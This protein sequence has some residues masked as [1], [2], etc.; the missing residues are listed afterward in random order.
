M[1]AKKQRTMNEEKKQRLILRLKTAKDEALLRR[2]RDKQAKQLARKVSRE[3]QKKRRARRTDSDQNNNVQCQ[4]NLNE[5]PPKKQLRQTDLTLNPTN[6]VQRNN[7]PP[8][9]TPRSVNLITN[10]PKKKQRRRTDSTPNPTNQV[11]PNNEPPNS[12]SVPG[13]S[14]QQVHRK[15]KP[16]RKEQ[17]KEYSRRYRAKKKEN[18][19]SA[20]E[21]K[22]KEHARYL[23]RKESKQ[24]K[25]IADMTAREQRKMR[26]RWRENTRSSRTRRQIAHDADSYM[27]GNSPPETPANPSGAENAAEHSQSGGTEKKKQGS[28]KA[29]RRKV[30]RDRA[31]AYV[32]LKKA[33]RELLDANRRADKWK[34]RCIRMEGTFRPKGV[35]P[36]PRTKVRKMLKGCRVPHDVRKR[37]EY[38]E[39]LQKQLKH[40]AEQAATESEKQLFARS[41]SGCI[42][43]KYKMKSNSKHLLSRR[44][45]DL[46]CQSRIHIR[47]IR[48]SA[49]SAMQVKQ[50]CSFL[51]DDAN[52]RICAGKREY[53]LR[54]GQKKQK[55]YLCDTMLNLHSKFC[56]QHI[57]VMSYATFCRLRPFWIVEPKAKDRE[58]CGCVKHDNM[59]FLVSKLNMLG[60]IGPKTPYEL[61]EA[62]ACYTGSKSCMYGECLDCRD[63]AI[64]R[65]QPSE[66]NNN[67]FFYRWSTRN[68]NRVRAKDGVPIVVK[69]TAKEK[70]ACTTD[71]MFSFLA[72]EMPS[73]KEHEYRMN[74]Q[75]NI[76]TE[77][78]ASLLPNEGILIID[79]SEN[80]S[81]KYSSETQSVHFGASRQQ[82]TL[83]TGVLY[84]MSGDRALGCKSFCSVSESLRHDPSAIWAHLKPIFNMLA[85]SFPQI[86]TL[87]IWSDGPTTQYRNRRNFGIFSVLHHFGNFK[88][89]TWNYTE[90]GHG[91]AAADGIG[92]WL[93]RQADGLVAHGT[94]IT[95]AS[96]L[97][98]ALQADR[99]ETELYM[100]T[101]DDIKAIDFQFDTSAVKCIK[102]TMKLHQLAWTNTRPKSL[103]MRYLSCLE[104]PAEA[105]C[106][107]YSVGG[108]LLMNV[109]VTDKSMPQP[110][111][112]TR[113][114]KTPRNMSAQPVAC[115]RAPKTPRN[116]SAQPVTRTRA[117]KKPRDMSAELV[118]PAANPETS[119]QQP[120]DMS[121][122]LVTPA[123]HPETSQQ[124]A[125]MS[126]EP[127]TPAANPET[128]SQQPADM[129]A[130]PATPAANPETSQQ[131]ADIPIQ[132]TACIL[133]YTVLLYTF[134]IQLFTH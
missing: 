68:E 110:V 62:V 56:K 53:I 39:C 5:P 108:M 74:H 98:S 121:A 23:S 93:K 122:E 42:M 9:S 57:T 35:S 107:H 15:L 126:A 134:C 14:N 19:L 96:V 119:S 25:L 80:Y 41:V 32:Q 52:S 59:K 95:D 63:K 100:V 118:T 3:S 69:V 85:R 86:D 51:E 17:W 131:P 109:K 16:S 129:S 6:H 54:R 50:V 105:I 90:S 120:A 10:R 47:A 117:P 72:K 103:S 21:Q 60:V 99:S 79:F 61:C 133:D 128:S 13:T 66:S 67:T 114:P 64:V 37:L 71:E 115:T 12:I 36:S 48:N 2:V 101:D 26:R 89:A 77:M 82:V 127:V 11:Q 65:V 75:Q 8:N 102:G 132:E 1:L 70:V 27:E 81:C 104:C 94:D 20:Q 44:Y 97:F 112:C 88:T 73:F 38:N 78:K 40:N 106:K 130:E 111:A 49:V 33:Q 84:F 125:D 43:G 124:P 92:G 46:S 83:H 22:V 4:L 87:H 116:M 45:T 34:K 31:L 30:R 76:R 18:P 58:T 28:K 24:I 55:R 113:A 123:A 7:E 29:G 91:K